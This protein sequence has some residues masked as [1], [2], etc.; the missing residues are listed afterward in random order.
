MPSL[1]DT[2]FILSLIDDRERWHRQ[3][4]AVLANEELPLLSTAPVLTEAFHFVHKSEHRQQK[5]WRLIDAGLL[6][7]AAITDADLP[8][9]E[10]LMLRYADRPMDFADASLVHVAG[11]EN[12][13]TVLTIDH[14]DFETYRFG[15]N[16]AFRILPAR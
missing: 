6:T 16:Q 4:T 11:R 8:A 3:C 2:G 5:V 13:D 15:R 10:T 7:I 14:D 1:I 12:I 9:L